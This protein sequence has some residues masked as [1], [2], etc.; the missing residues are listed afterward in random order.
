[1]LRR[2]IVSMQSESE[3]VSW[4]LSEILIK[5]IGNLLAQANSN[6]IAG[7]IGNAFT[8]MQTIRLLIHHDL[9]EKEVKKILKSEEEATSMIN[10]T[11]MYKGFNVD[12]GKKI[13][14]F[15]GR[16]KYVLYHNLVMSCLKEH[17]YSIPP[18][19][20]THRIV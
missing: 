2:L 9:G 16:A 10:N 7:R 5:Q 8:I 15:D 4:N 19:A 11:D 20:E 14:F 6:F 17:G 18:K 12:E 1:M 13:L 3:K